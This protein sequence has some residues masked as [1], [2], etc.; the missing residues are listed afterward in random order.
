MNVRILVKLTRPTGD[1]AA[2]AAE[3]SRQA[4]VAA[5]YAASVSAAWHA[6]V[7]HCSDAAECD[8][9]ITRLQQASGSYEAVERDGRKQRL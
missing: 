2:I 9:A 7:L 6:L 1:H 4:G 8:L 5:K 3:A